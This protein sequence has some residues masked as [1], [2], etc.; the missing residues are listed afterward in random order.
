MRPENSRGLEFVQVKEDFPSAIARSEFSRRGLLA[1]FAG[2]AA[3]A[4]LPT[5]PVLAATAAPRTKEPIRQRRL[6]MRNLH[7]GETLTVTY[8]TAGRYDAAALRRVDHFMRDHRDHSEHRIDPAVLD[9]LHDLVGR[10]KVTKPIGIVCG[11]RSPKTNALLRAKSSGVAKRSLHMEGRAIDIRVPGRTV[12]AVSKHAIA[13]RRGGVGRYTR[14]NFVH[15]D[16]GR[17]RTWGS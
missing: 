5:S 2:L 11:Y 15:I 17:V 4:I 10:L 7:T 9:F 12:K 3:T 1:V 14:S 13:M 6:A 8:S 16:S